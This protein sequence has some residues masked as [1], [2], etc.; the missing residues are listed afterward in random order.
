MNITITRINIKAHLHSTICVPKATIQSTLVDGSIFL[1]A[2]CRHLTTFHRL[3]SA[4]TQG[5]CASGKVTHQVTQ[6]IIFKYW[7]PTEYIHIQKRYYTTM[8]LDRSTFSDGL[9]ID[10]GVPPHLPIDIVTS[11]GSLCPPHTIFFAPRFLSNESGIKVCL[12]LHANAL[13]HSCYESRT[14]WSHKICGFCRSND[15]LRWSDR[16]LR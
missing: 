16:M 8:Y 12:C 2:S 10:F 6:Q 5:Y 15:P 14:K 9:P 4:C 13:L 1:P 11:C 7:V 3:S